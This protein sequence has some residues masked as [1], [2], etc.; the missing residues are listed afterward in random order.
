[1][2]SMGLEPEGEARRN[3][4]LSSPIHSTNHQSKTNHASPF[5]TV[6]YSCSAL[7]R[8]SLMIHSVLPYGGAVCTATHPCGWW[9]IVPTLFDDSDRVSNSQS[10]IV[11][12]RHCPP[13]SCP[14]MSS[15]HPL[16]NTSAHH[17]HTYTPSR[18]LTASKFQAQKL[19]SQEDQRKAVYSWSPCG[20][21]HERRTSIFGGSRECQ[22]DLS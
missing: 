4:L 13:L 1:M 16:H 5:S 9:R 3:H 15:I 20:F 2:M 21:E 6:S 12:T 14:L 18:R 7:H 11:V 19:P 10:R 17:P 22:H 8:C